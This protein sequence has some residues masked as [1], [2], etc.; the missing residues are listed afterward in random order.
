VRIVGRGG[1]RAVA[2]REEARGAWVWLVTDNLHT[3][4]AAAVAAIHTLLGVPVG[5]VLQ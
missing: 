3:R 5:D 1:L 2:V 4:A